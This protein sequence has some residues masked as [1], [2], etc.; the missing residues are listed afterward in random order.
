MKL[1]SDLDKI[2]TLIENFDCFEQ[3]PRE[4]FL[5]SVVRR[6][7]RSKPDYLR[8]RTESIEKKNKI[9]ILCKHNGLRLLSAKEDLSVFGITQA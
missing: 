7:S 3:R 8:R 6:I 9:T 1:G 4:N 2:V 5:Q